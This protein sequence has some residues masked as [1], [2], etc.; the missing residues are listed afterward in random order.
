MKTLP[1]SHQELNGAIESYHLKLKSELS[2]DSHASSWE[3]VDWFVRTFS[4]DFHFMHWFYI[5][6]EEMWSL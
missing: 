3:R 5:Y 2:S 6:S 1:V 4:A